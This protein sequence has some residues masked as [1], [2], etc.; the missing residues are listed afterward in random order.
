MAQIKM[1]YGI[2]LGTTN[3]AICKIENGEPTIKKTD[4]QM[5]TLPSCVSFSKKKVI[6]VGLTAYNGL[7]SDK[8][9]ATKKWTKLDENVFIE[10]KRTMGLDTQYESKNMERSFSSEELSAEVLKTLKSFVSDDNINACVIT[11]PAKFKT[12]QIAATKRAAAMAG[13]EHCELL[14]EPIA[15][16]MAYGLSSAKKDGMWLVFDFGGGTFDA[17]LLKVE[18][19]IMQVK[20]TEGDN[21][22]GGKNLDYAIVDEIIIPYLQ[23]NYTIDDILEDDTKKQILRDAMKFYA[24]QAKNQLSFKDKCDII[25]GLAEFGEDDEGE[26]IQLE[27]II[28]KDQIVDVLSPIFQKAI[29]ICKNLLSRNNLRGS[30][31][32]SLILVGGP[33]Y[34]P[35]LREMLK[36]QITQNVDT[37]ID[38][39]TAVARGAALFAS[40]I[41]T[42]VK[43]GVI[44][45]SGPTIALDLAYES[46]SVETMEFVSVKLLKNECTGTIPS[47]I[48]I[49][50]TRNDKGW[51][52]GKVEVNEIGDVIECQLMEGK[53]NSFAIV[54]YDEKGSTIPCFPNE[55]NIMQGIVVGSAV[56][57]YNIGIEAHDTD[58]DRAVFVPLKGLEKN[59]PIPAIGVRNGL[60]IPSQLR[61][62]MTA[63]RLV[64]P[65]YQGEHNAEGSSAIYNDHVTDI[66]ITGDDVPAL[67]PGNSDIDITVK[68]DRSQMM[69]V[70]VTFPVIGET[71]EREIDVKSRSGVSEYELKERFTEAKRKLRNLQSASGISEHEISEAKSML[72]DID[73]RFDGEKGTEDGKMHLLADLRRAFLKMEE[74]EKA[75]EWES[76]ETELREEFDRLEK[77]N[78]DL[79]NKHDEQVAELRRQ[80]D[81]AIR[82]HDVRMGRQVL[83]EINSVFVSVTLIYQLV[84]FVRH[85]N[86]NFNQVKWKDAA[87][88][89][90]LLNQGLETINDNP[91]VEVLHP[92]VCSVYDLI[93]VVDLEGQIIPEFSFYGYGV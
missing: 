72:S 66:V 84:G 62:G 67:I 21:Y 40:G 42:E 8:S 87:R 90:Q 31:L 23:E 79:G 34:S 78:N 80:T 26:E 4:A 58:R 14:Q 9:N 82:K 61:P 86:T 60:K 63:D 69:T 45:A 46:S 48:F 53:S 32:D 91:N 11:I 93:D 70:E 75:H 35:I 38:P 73:G 13:I 2:D 16:S 43:A 77:A 27:M 12:D 54:A 51:S 64:I 17:A 71:V 29:D 74:T 76:L 3:S 5:D 15:A 56:L 7:R 36:N 28:T 52:S 83:S 18:D 44:G 68:V 22:L 59:Q 81:M 33:T 55:V 85:Y 20:D 65:I 37:S 30:D 19:G 57:P 6:R 24:E 89:R 50:L 49:E 10:F 25:S 1:K 41:D 39:M 88:A 92:L 47:K